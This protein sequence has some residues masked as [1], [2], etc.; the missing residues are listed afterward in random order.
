MLQEPVDSP[1]SSEYSALQKPLEHFRAKTKRLQIHPTELAVLGVVVT[2]LL[3]LPW[4]LG[5]MRL[6]AQIPSLVLALAGFVLALVP[7]NYTEEHTGANRFRLVMWPKLIRFPLFWLGLA[8][9]G[10]VALQALNPAWEYRTDGQVWWMRPLTPTPWLPAGVDVPFATGGPWRMLTIYTSVWLTVCTLWVGFTRRR[11]LQRLLIAVAINGVALAALGLAQ[12]LLPNGKMFWFW[13]PP[14][15]AVI[16]S[17]FI[18]KNHGAAYLILT[19]CVTCGLAAWYYLRGLRRLEKSNPAG[20]LAFFATGIAVAV[21]V[22]Y[23]RGATLVMLVFLTVCIVGFVLHQLF[24]KAVHRKPSVAIVLILIFGYFLKIGLEA[25][26][27]N[28]AWTHLRQGISG[29]DG[30]L[31]GRW[32]ATKA[33]IDLA[34]AHWPRGAGAGSFRFLFPIYQQRY[35]EIFTL[36]GRRMVWENAHN[37][38]VQTVAELG[39]GGC[40]LVALAVGYVLIVLVRNYA[41]QNPLSGAVVLGL[42]LVSIYSW[43]DFPF[44]NS[45]FLILWWTIAVSAAMWATMEERGVKG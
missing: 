43:W 7:R 14:R 31:Q 5:G 42:A 37:D 15:D 39:L 29:A 19:L 24:S 33:S 34:S 2:H 21:L 22:S 17:S 13:P 41:W 28:E 1:S 9:L 25:V 8:F 36:G 38:P 44:Q 32:L 4:A 20:V 16:F 12:K 6:W 45:A 10:Y 30:S 3:L 23:A 26:R 18:Y 40:L 35:P 27:S 11:T